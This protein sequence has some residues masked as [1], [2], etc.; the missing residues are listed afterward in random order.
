MHPNWQASNG[1]SLLPLPPNVGQ[2]AALACRA[3]ARVGGSGRHADGCWYAQAGTQ[4]LVHSGRHA[5]RH[6]GCGHPPGTSPGA[7]RTHALVGSRCPPASAPP[8]AWPGRTAFAP[9]RS[10]GAAPRASRCRGTGRRHP[11]RCAGHRPGRAARPAF[12]GCRAACRSA[13]SWLRRVGIC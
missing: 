9:R 5:G 12:V 1:L 8:S 10:G 4:L 13:C 3:S 11:V 6:A 7:G 2:R